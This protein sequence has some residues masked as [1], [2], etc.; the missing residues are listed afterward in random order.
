MDYKCDECDLVASEYDHDWLVLTERYANSDVS[1]QDFSFHNYRCLLNFIRKKGVKDMSPTFE[2]KGKVGDKPVE[3]SIKVP[4]IPTF[5]VKAR[6][7]IED[8]EREFDRNIPLNIAPNLEIFQY[9]GDLALVFDYRTGKCA[10]IPFETKGPQHSTLISN[11]DQMGIY[12]D[13]TI[14]LTDYEWK[15]MSKEDLNKWI[16][17]FGRYP[18]K[19]PGLGIMRALREK[20]YGVL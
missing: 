17:F 7:M 10:W 3:I 14:K 8:V 13:P 12:V 9:K 16:N 2:T 1:P 11:R 6:K 15:L 4:D 5:L 19:E 18:A 20:L